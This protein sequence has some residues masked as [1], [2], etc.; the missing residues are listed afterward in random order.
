MVTESSKGRTNKSVVL[1]EAGRYLIYAALVYATAEFMKWN[2]GLDHSEAK[3]SEYSYVEYAQSFLLLLSGLISFKFYIS[4]QNPVYKNIFLLIFGLS[5]ITLIREQDIYFEEF[6]GKGIWPIPVFIIICIIGYKAFSAGK[7]IWDEL[8]LY[9]KTKSYAFF[10]FGTL[11][12]FVFSRL[13]GRTKFWEAIM[14]DKYFRS[15]KNAA[16]ECVELYGYLFFF[17]SVIELVIENA[18]KNVALTRTFT[19]ASKNQ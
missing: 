6:I 18:K 17:I 11:T 7:Q 10:C 5:A 14:E 15:V 1:K 3:F 9:V 12:I 2:A 19:A 16:E 8:A 13:F 4:K